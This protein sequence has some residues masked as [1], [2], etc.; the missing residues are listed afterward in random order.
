LF[1]KKLASNKNPWVTG[2]TSRPKA[3][4]CPRH[5]KKKKRKKEEIKNKG[6]KERG[7]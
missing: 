7:R 4:N 5:D 2:P 3:S 1:E 6:N